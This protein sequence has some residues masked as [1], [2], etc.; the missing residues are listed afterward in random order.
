MTPLQLLEPL[1]AARLPSPAG[2]SPRSSMKR[3][4]Q[5]AAMA[6][7][8][9]SL[10][11]ATRRACRRSCRSWGPSL[12]RTRTGASWSHGRWV[13]PHSACDTFSFV[14]C[15][16]AYHLT[17]NHCPLLPEDDGRQGERSTAPP[18]V[19]PSRASRSLPG[20]AAFASPE[21]NS[22]ETPTP[23]PQRRPQRSM[24]TV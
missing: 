8:R 22:F 7:G 1:A 3:T 16:A 4:K 15:L 14:C 5:M 17:R 9:G 23:P 18:E 11:A 10:C 20:G 13:P 24:L 21:S 19:P 6:A 12:Q 2:A